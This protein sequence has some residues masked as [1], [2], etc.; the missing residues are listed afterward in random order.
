MWILVPCFSLVPSS[1]FSVL[2]VVKIGMAKQKIKN[3]FVHSHDHD[4]DHDHHGHNHHHHH[5]GDVSLPV[6]DELDPA[7]RSLNDALRVSFVV[8]QLLMVGLLLLYAFSN[9]FN[10]PEQEVAVRLRFGKVVGDSREQQVIGPGGPHFALPYPIENVVWIPTSDQSLSVSD[11][12]WY[13]VAAADAGKTAD[14]LAQGKAGPLDPEKDGSLITG[15]ANIVH[16]RWTLQY[17]ITDPVDFITHIAEPSRDRQVLLAAADRVVRLAAEQAIVAAVAEVRADDIFTPQAGYDRAVVRMQEALDAMGTGIRVVNLTLT[18]RAVPLS[19]KGDFEAVIN[20]EN[21]KAK[22][23]DE[24]EKERARILGEAAGEAALPRAGEPGPLLKLIRAYE[25]AS[26]REDAAAMEALDAQLDD[27]FATLAVPDGE[28]RIAIGG[29]AATLMK[30]AIGFRTRVVSEV[31]AEAR[32]FQ[33]E[34]EQYLKY[35]DV[36]KATKWWETARTVLTGDVETMYL[37]P[38]Q[39][40]LELNRDPDVR[41]QREREAIQE[42]K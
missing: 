28:A 17:R 9:V 1:V 6:A 36:V 16:A 12:F 31:E 37:P 35:P 29:E 38:G 39:P 11:A 13:E 23:I 24:A 14:E 22:A 3:P 26:A 32:I 20:A 33:S 19:V 30:D 34:L 5:H 7:Q 21:T 15:D 40:Y 10:V 8:L 4:H 41:A 18:G 25:D 42:L 2:S 27:A